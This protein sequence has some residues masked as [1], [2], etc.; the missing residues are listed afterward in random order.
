MD[1]ARGSWFAASFEGTWHGT[2]AH[3]RIGRNGY[4]PSS[5]AIL[6]ATREAR[7][8]GSHAERRPVIVSSNAAATRIRGS[9]GLIS[10]TSEDSQRPSTKARSE[11]RRVGKECRCR[12][13]PEQ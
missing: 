6:G 1:H 3:A 7:R 10:N 12:W 2:I 9:H 5:I 13:S 8:A 4:Y 11:E